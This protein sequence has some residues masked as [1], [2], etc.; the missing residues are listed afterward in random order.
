[1]KAPAIVPDNH[2]G[3]SSDNEISVQKQDVGSAQKL[4]QLGKARLLNVNQWHQLSG[5]ATAV[6][7]L[8]DEQGKEVNR[9]AKLGDHFKIDIP[10]PGT[11]TGKGNDWVQIEAIEDN[12][13]ADCEIIAI[14]VRPVSNPQNSKEDVAHFFS[15]EAS[16]TFSITRNGNIV[17]AA[18]QGRN[19]KPNLKAENLL[20]KVRN[21]VVGTSAIA[22]MNKPQWKSLVKGLL[23]E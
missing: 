13:E 8:T 7:Q 15:E 18:V 1:M 19:E 16:S 11:I 4:F 17:T 5:M 10:G 12:A 22:G 9:P 2:S 23:S 20:D 21:A 14:R 6:F 3:A